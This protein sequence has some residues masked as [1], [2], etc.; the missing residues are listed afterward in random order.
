VALLD[1][2]QIFTAYK[3]FANDVDIGTATSDYRRLRMGGGNSSGYLYGAY[4]RFG[5]GLHLSYNY[6]WSPGGGDVIWATD[7]PTSRISVG[8]GTIV[9]AVGGVGTAPTTQR[10]LANSTGVTVNGTFSNQSD[11]NAKQDFAP[12]DPSE[13]LEKVA[14]LPLS[15]WSYKDDP[16]TRH[17]GPMGQDFYSAFNIGTDE[18]HIAPLDEG[19]VALAAIQGLNQKLT[20]ELKRRDAENA[21]LKARLSALEKHVASLSSKGN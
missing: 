18:K 7:G 1:A 20:E 3:A 17:V 15:E 19:G 4:P 6:Y 16:A 2:G 5:D 12:I 14:G 10:L 21:E 9:L 11:R 13:I 8:Y